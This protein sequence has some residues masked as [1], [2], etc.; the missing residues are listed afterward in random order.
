MTL[1]PDPSL[2]ANLYAAGHLD[3]AVLRVALPYRRRLPELVPEG[4]AYLWLM[5]YAKGGE[6]LKFRVHAPEELVP[7]L[8]EA[9]GSTAERFLEQL[10]PAQEGDTRPSRPDAPP[11]DAEDRGDPPDRTF[12]STE[13]GRS[14]VSLGGE[15]FL[16]QDRFRELM[17]H[18]LSRGCDRV[19]DAFEALEGPPSLGQRRRLLL[20]ILSDALPASGLSRSQA[21]AYLAYHRDWLIRFP[22]LKS[23]GD[24]EQAARIVAQIEERAT[25]LE[26]VIEALAGALVP[27]LD[28]S[29]DAGG[30]GQEPWHQAVSALVDYTAA[31]RDTP[32]A[33]LDPYA[34]DVVFPP[35]FKALHGTA[36][37]IGIRALEEAFAHH[38]LLAAVAGASSDRYQRIALIPS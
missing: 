23:G 27:R 4:R 35:L 28:G 3:A 13:Y 38:L 15:P 19:L 12:L 18:C 16:G 24:A 30:S 21:A 1:W 37:Q 11:I 5:R 6:H 7:P 20:E 32:D 8:A 29:V 22:I 14:H 17:T 31:Y 10:P 33:L 25:R 9:L 36:N 34:E 2:T 26:P